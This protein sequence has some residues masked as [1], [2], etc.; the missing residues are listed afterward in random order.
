MLTALLTK[1]WRDH[2][3][4]I[5]SWAGGLIAIAAIQLWV[6]P[7]IRESSEGVSEMIESLPQA[8][9]EVFRMTDYTSGAGYL[10]VELF[11]FMVP[12]ILIAVGVT[13]GAAATADEERRGTADILLSLPVS[14]VRVIVTKMIAT[15]VVLLGLCVVLTA[16]LAIGTRLVDLDVPLANLFAASFSCALLGM[17]YASIGFLIGALVGRPGIATGAG[18]ALAIAAFVLYSLA[19]LVDT[20][21]AVTPVNPFQWALGFDP[22]VNGLAVSNIGWLVGSSIVLLAASVL[23]FNRRDIST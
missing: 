8:L 2:W 20:F 15:A 5:A 17:L 10:N 3:R 13:W 19:P 12:L 6:Y 18:F 9:Q 22:M 23:A 21:D 16:T 7:S 1:S 14:R 11:S 4:G